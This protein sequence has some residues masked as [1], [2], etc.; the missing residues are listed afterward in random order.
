MS[1]PSHEPIAGDGPPPRRADLPS[2][3]SNPRPIPWWTWGLLGFL[4]LANLLA[5]MDRWLFPA[6]ALPIGRELD[7]WDD[8]AD[9]LEA[10]PLVAAALWA[11][12][13]GYFADRVRRPRLLA[14]GIAAFGLAGVASGLAA[15]YPALQRARALVG[16]GTATAGVVSLTMLMDVFPRTVRARALAVYFL[17]GPV[18][19]ALALCLG[20]PLAHATTWQT[21][22]LAAGAPALVLALASLTLPDPVRGLSEGV[23]VAQL[24][25]HES[26]GPSAE[27]Y[28]DLMVNSSFTY[29]VFGLTFTAFAISALTAWLPTFLMGA[30]GLPEPVAATFT[31]TLPP[32]AAAVGLLIGA[33][34]AD[35]WGRTDPRAYFLIPALAAAAAVPCWLV[36]FLG[37]SRPWQPAALFATVAL[38]SVNLGPCFAILAS[39]A[40]PNM[41]GVACGAAVAVVQL[42]GD[43]WAPRLTGWAAES[44]GQP[45]LMATTFGRVLAMIGANPQVVGGRSPENV[46][47]ALLFAAP[48]LAAAGFVLLAG[49]RHLPRE[50]ALMLA[51]LRAAPTRSS[52]GRA[53]DPN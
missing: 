11:P 26:F 39:V 52:A 14:L 4:F 35:R 34:L 2:R 12:T 44:F 31:G 20:P 45:D 28:V 18:G 19:A 48:T 50:A 24:R 8:Q 42:L 40:A 7:L 38:A 30:R 27:D 36:A 29:S 47:A 5:S 32:A 15:T 49:A 41:R 25:R 51:N 17:A 10:L 16:L 53:A 37:P 1:Q 21:A 43:A 46:A 6:L 33:W 3:L 22:F 23:P 9:W 13:L